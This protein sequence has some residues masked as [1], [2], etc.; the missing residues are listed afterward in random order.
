VLVGCATSP[1]SQTDNLCD[2]FREK[3]GWYEDARKS[4]S[5]WGV[6]ISVMMAIMHQESRFV[7]T[8]K[9]P[10]KKIFGFIPG[11]RP[12]DAYGY[13]QAKDDT[14]TWYQ[15]SSGNYGADRDDFGDAI[16]FVGWYGN[17]SNKQNGIAKDDTFRLYLAYHEGHGGYAAKSYQSKGWLVDVARKVDRQANT[18]NSQLKGCVQELDQEKWWKLW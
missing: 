2:I 1:P 14:W 5:Q 18:Y 17:M 9:P 15:R 11:P 7:A 6:P 12:S 16:D 8:A 3:S 10:R 4:R 13:S